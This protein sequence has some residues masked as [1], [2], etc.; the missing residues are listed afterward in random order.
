MKTRSNFI[1][2]IMKV[3]DLYSYH[4]FLLSFFCLISAGS[5]QSASV[6]IGDSTA[7]GASVTD[8]QTP[9]ASNAGALTYAFANSGYTNSAATPVT[10]TVSGIKF[11]S[12]NGSGNGTPFFAIYSGTNIA[13][14]SN[15]SV[16]SIGTPI[17]AATVG[18]HNASYSAALGSSSFT[19]GAGQTL[20]TGFFQDSSVIPYL[21]A[22]GDSEYIFNNTAG[23]PASAGTG[24]TLPTSV[25]NAL[26][27]NASYAGLSR[28]YAYNA[29][30]SVIPEPASTA[31]LLLSTL[32]L[33]RRRRRC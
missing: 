24:Y 10:I 3:T 16:I 19:L 12:E 8:R 28:T 4:A 30:I 2:N 32:G 25:P 7:Q 21:D 15:F 18:V 27:N 5:A 20:I 1:Y 14:A 33:L 11:W 17:S 6:F 22:S 31:L 29:E 13:L 9:D 23:G 26:T